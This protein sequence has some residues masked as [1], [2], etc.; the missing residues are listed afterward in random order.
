MPG[1]M[2]SESLDFE[3]VEYRHGHTHANFTLCVTRN[4]LQE[5]AGVMRAICKCRCKIKRIM[6]AFSRLARNDTFMVISQ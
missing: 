6:L 2:E 1:H 5:F 3:Q 4:R